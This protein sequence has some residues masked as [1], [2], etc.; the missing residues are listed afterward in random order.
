[1]GLKQQQQPCGKKC[2]R[3]ERQNESTQLHCSHL[4]KWAS[5]PY[6]PHMSIWDSSAVAVTPGLHCCLL[7]C[8]PVPGR[9][10]PQGLT[11]YNNLA[12][13]DPPSSPLS[14]EKRCRQG[15]QPVGS[16]NQYDSSFSTSAKDR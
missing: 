9:I 15:Q 10:L 7:V 11:R 3:H 13:H 14:V 1:M 12:L 8:L 4:T 2:L 16:I 5:Q 6:T